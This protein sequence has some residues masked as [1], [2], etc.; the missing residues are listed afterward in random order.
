[1]PLEGM[2]LYAHPPKAWCDA[3]EVSCQ[4]SNAQELQ[5]EIGCEA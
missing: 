4:V 3:Q 5:T 2:K 1:M